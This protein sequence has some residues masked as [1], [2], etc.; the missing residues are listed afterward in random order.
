MCQRALVTPNVFHNVLSGEDLDSGFYR[1]MLERLLSWP[2]QWY[3][4]KPDYYWA[5]LFGELFSSRLDRG[6]QEMYFDFRSTVRICEVTPSLLEE[7]DR[8]RLLNF[9]DALRLSCAID[10]NLEA[11][12]TWEPHHFTRTE[13]DGKSVQQ[14]GYFPLQLESED[15][16]ARVP[17][18]LEMGIFSP[19]SLLK[20]L[21][22]CHSPPADRRP[23]FAI[24]TIQIRGGDEN[25]ETTAWVTIRDVRG[26]PIEATGCG[27]SPLAALQRAIDRCIDRTIELPQ[28]E[29]YRI[30]CP[31]ALLYRADAPVEA[32]VHVWC[33]GIPFQASAMNSSILRAASE[34]Y[35][36][37]INS[38]YHCPHIQRN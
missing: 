5:F 24:D 28:R 31:N 10:R 17:H 13:S 8:Y 9:A 7:V 16:E 38:I 15:I 12:V 37:T 19:S 25:D 23:Y 18:I 22:H 4:T 11:I 32:I 30:F 3:M 14:S 27:M 6:L 33:G 20:Y 2:I 34:A 29:I 1:A 21:Y 35:L 26:N 36:A